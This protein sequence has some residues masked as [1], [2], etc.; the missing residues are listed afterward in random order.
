MAYHLSDA[1]PLP[2][3]RLSR[4]GR[5]RIVSGQKSVRPKLDPPHITIFMSVRL[6]CVL[7]ANPSQTG[8]NRKVLLSLA[9]LFTDP[10]RTQTL[11]GCV[12]V[13]LWERRGFQIIK[14]PYYAAV[15]VRG[16]AGGSSG[17]RPFIGC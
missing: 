1:P 16:G 2:I 13:S 7:L 4:V 3:F 8:R 12:R 9:G 11:S 10:I 14:H 15:L 5:A 6:L 17:S